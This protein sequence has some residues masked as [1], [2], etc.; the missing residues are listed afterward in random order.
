MEQEHGF[1]KYLRM[2]CVVR[3]GTEKLQTGVDRPSPA[4]HSKRCPNG[5]KDVADG[6]EGTQ[7]RVEGNRCKETHT[8]T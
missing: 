2:G 6:H 7:A 1:R 4:V 3:V 8:L 5:V